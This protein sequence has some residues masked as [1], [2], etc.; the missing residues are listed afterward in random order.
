MVQNK[1][2]L[3]F[4]LLLLRENMTGPRIGYARLLVARN[5]IVVVRIA[6]YR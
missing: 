5:N 4:L 1:A 3:R 6:G 2:Y